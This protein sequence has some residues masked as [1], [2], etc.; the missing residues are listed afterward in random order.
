MRVFLSP[1]AIVAAVA[2]SVP[3]E[4]S[5]FSKD[6]LVVLRLG[7]GVAAP[8]AISNP[9]SLQEYTRSGELRQAVT[10][11][12]NEDGILI[13]GFD[14]G[15]LT[16]PRLTRD[17]DGHGLMLCGYRPPF[18]GTPTDPLN[19]RSPFQAPRALLRVFSDAVPSAPRTITGAPAIYSATELGA[20]ILVSM[21]QIN[22]SVALLA[23][24]SS[25]TGII[26]SA[27]AVAKL[28]DGTGFLVIS[29]GGVQ[30]VSGLPK[31]ISPPTPL[32]STSSAC[33]V[34]ASPGL[35]AV[36]VAT[37]VGTVV[38]YTLQ[39]GA[40]SV[41]ATFTTGASSPVRGITA[42]YSGPHPV[43]FAVTAGKVWKIVDDQSTSA[44]TSI[45]TAEA[46]YEFGAVQL[47]PV[48]VPAAPNAPD[49]TG[50]T[51]VVTS[52]RKAV[53][54]SSRSVFQVKGFTVDPSGL[55]SVEFRKDT[56]EKWIPA[57]VKGGQWSVTLRPNGK[58]RT[59]HV[60]IR[61]RDVLGNESSLT[62]RTIRFF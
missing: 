34:T 31:G 2:F 54:L 45:A 18:F 39:N 22:P 61:A 23:D 1:L 36:Y 59:Y 17:V 29:P 41:A 44:M 20:A 50:P 53:S 16:G 13:P 7:D 24:D 51:I 10:I 30:F 58:R 5:P 28:V 38:K 49:V 37:N 26:Y 12:S 25:L 62:V 48:A 4:A 46:N 32:F 60:A 8:T 11:P 35:G 40:F 14:S 56:H 42:D 15:S 52:P 9:I 21:P 3:L 57:S 6:N 19:T 33:D 55:Q 47:A 27:S 43:I